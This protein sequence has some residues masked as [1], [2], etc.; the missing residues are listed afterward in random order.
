MPCVG[1]TLRELC[2]YSC[3]NTTGVNI[4]FF[5]LS[6]QPERARFISFSVGGA[7]CGCRQTPT[8]LINAQSLFSDHIYRTRARPVYIDAMKTDNAVSGK[9]DSFLPTFPCHKKRKHPTN[10]LFCFVNSVQSTAEQEKKLESSKIIG[11]GV[12]R[13]SLKKEV[14]KDLD[15]IDETNQLCDKSEKSLLFDTLF[16]DLN[17]LVGHQSNTLKK[18]LKELAV[19]GYT[20]EG[21]YFQQHYLVR[22]PLYNDLSCS[23]PPK[24]QGAN[25]KIYENLLERHGIQ[26][27]DGDVPI[28]EVHCT[29]LKLF[30]NTSRIIVASAHNANY[31]KR[32]Y[33]KFITCSVDILSTANGKIPLWA[34]EILK[35]E[36]ILCAH[37][38][39]N[40][41]KECALNN[42]RLLKFR[43]DGLL[44]A[45]F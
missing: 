33:G 44:S 31:I 9:E 6:I 42:V 13:S 39:M 21:K 35:P 24:L 37:H 32:I 10:C 20:R 30:S 2:A 16:V 38:V 17:Y 11:S 41:Q 7:G 45:P 29:L 14:L 34:E 43:Y 18:I 27:T 36:P 12:I 25:L 22:S 23:R 15:N 4:S 28:K 3:H 26:W 40:S 8:P 1:K 19:V 5:I